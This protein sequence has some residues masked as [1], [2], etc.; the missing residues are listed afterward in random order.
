MSDHD[1]NDT[2]PEL[3]PRQREVLDLLMTGLGEK[4]VAE[5]L[6]LS[7][8]TVHNHVKAIYRA[9]G[10]SSRAELFARFIRH[11]HLTAGGEHLQNVV[12]EGDSDACSILAHAP[13]FIVRIDREGVISF[14]NRADPGYSID[15]AVGTHCADW[16]APEDNARM[17][18]VMEAAFR[19]GTT[20]ECVISALLE[21]QGAPRRFHLRLQPVTDGRS[22]EYLI[23]VARPLAEPDAERDLREILDHSDTPIVEIDREGLIQYITVSPSGYDRTKVIGTRLIDYVVPDDQAVVKQCIDACFE[24]GRPQQYEVRVR[25]ADGMIRRYASQIGP[26]RRNGVIASALIIARIIEGDAHQCSAVQMKKS[27][28]G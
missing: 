20:Q 14:L 24:T 21:E 4:D 22:V 26:V 25:G 9:L 17:Q 23:G 1:V 8:H 27:E 11:Q 18:E 15:D 6:F 2:W 12:S 16:L 5:K 3:T 19:S 10:V 28:T 7:R 13:D